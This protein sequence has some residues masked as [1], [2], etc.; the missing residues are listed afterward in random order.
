MPP[1]TRQ[2]CAVPE[3][4]SRRLPLRHHYVAHC[5]ARAPGLI[6]SVLPDASNLPAFCA[7]VLTCEFEALE[8]IAQL[9][10]TPAF[11]AAA[12]VLGLAGAFALIKHRSKKTIPR[13]P[14]AKL[15]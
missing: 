15:D 11:L 12:V 7:F 3:V 1:P 10:S 14:D 13:L 2:R 5:S 4:L 6:P 9:M 8:V